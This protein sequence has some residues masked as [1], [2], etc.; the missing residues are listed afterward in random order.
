[1]IVHKVEANLVPRG[2]DG[3]IGIPE[4]TLEHS[5]S[6]GWVSDSGWS[7]S[8]ASSGVQNGPA[9]TKSLS[10]TLTAASEP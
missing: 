10:T 6:D 5:S 3:S 8:S 9:S 4:T 2:D 1:M 7:I